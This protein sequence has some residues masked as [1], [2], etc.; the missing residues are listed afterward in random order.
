MT[1]RR[2]PRAVRP[3]RANGVVKRRVP[4]PRARVPLSVA[5][6]RRTTS[7]GAGRQVV[8]WQKSV[9]THPGP[10]TPRG[11]ARSKPRVADAPLGGD[12]VNRCAKLERV[13]IRPRSCGPWPGVSQGHVRIRSKASRLANLAPLTGC[14]AFATWSTGYPRHLSA[15]RE[16]ELRS[17]WSRIRTVPG[18]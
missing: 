10:V 6:R 17:G 14:L 18:G 5:C 7:A 9:R 16:R 3:K 15:R 1:T 4:L 13:P 12:T 11:L 2:L 8:G